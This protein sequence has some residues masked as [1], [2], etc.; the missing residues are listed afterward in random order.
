LETS[1]TKV[2]GLHETFSLRQRFSHYIWTV[3]GKN[4]VFFA[5]E[6]MP[7]TYIGNLTI[8]FTMFLRKKLPEI[9]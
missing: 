3:E 8:G 9:F 2:N 4:F 6:K 7:L 5:K 1:G